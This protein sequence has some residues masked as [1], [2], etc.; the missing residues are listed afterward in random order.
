MLIR[1][2][3][4]LQE[5]CGVQAPASAAVHAH[6][7]DVVQP[8]VVVQA[9]S[10][11]PA[12]ASGAAAPQ[13]DV[14]MAEAEDG[15][16]EPAPPQDFSLAPQPSTAQHPQPQQQSAPEAGTAMETDNEAEAAPAL[17]PRLVEA[18]QSVGIDLTFLEALP[19][20]LRMEV[21][22]AMLAD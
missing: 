7:A 9:P 13:A 11:Q 20:H 2:I 8:V 17:D 22:V 6:P 18:A 10:A 21:G 14:E 3:A 19:A 4:M 12:P 1:H 15:A 16:S 5:H